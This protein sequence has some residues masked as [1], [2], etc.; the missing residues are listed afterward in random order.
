[1]SVDGTGCPGVSRRI[2]SWL[3]LRRLR[4]LELRRTGSFRLPSSSRVAK[5]IAEFE[6]G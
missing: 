6:M 4:C 2:C 5:Y 1:M 3:D